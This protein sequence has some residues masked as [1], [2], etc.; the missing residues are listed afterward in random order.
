MVVNRNAYTCLVE[1]TEGKRSLG[2]L[3]CRLEDYIKMGLK[4]IGYGCGL[5]PA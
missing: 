3:M 1:N 4:E 5:D 2:R